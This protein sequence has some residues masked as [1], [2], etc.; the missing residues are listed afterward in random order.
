MMDGI[1][2]KKMDL[3]WFSGSGNT[4]RL[5][6][7]FAERL[8]QK[9]WTV[10][11]IPIEKGR[12]A[13]FDPGAVFG[14]AFPTHCFSI[15]LMVRAFISRLPQ[16]S[17]TPA[18]FLG[19][20]GL[21]SG[22]VRGHLKLILKLK[23]FQCL[24]ARIIR[25]PDSY[26]PFCGNKAHQRLIDKSLKKAEWYADRIAAGKYGWFRVPLVSDFAEMFCLGFFTSRKLT[27]T[28]RTSVHV[29]TGLCLHCGN[30]LQSCPMRALSFDLDGQLIAPN[31][32]C[33]N[34]LRCVA[35]CPNDALRHLFFAPYRGE[36]ADE[37]LYRFRHEFSVITSK[38]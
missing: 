12:P 20:H 19:T 34:C 13:A 4:L 26:F 32:K 35:V 8:R 23:G 28:T 15:P 1:A 25:M 17:K 33:Q 7:R 37:L 9:D 16:V 18:V 27:E 2:N 14:L 30:C 11:L 5:A 24:A 36:P 6:Q 38:E 3:Y 29:K 22:G 31:E 21:Y 10:R